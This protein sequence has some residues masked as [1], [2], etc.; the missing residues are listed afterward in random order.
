[1]K[2]VKNNIIKFVP[3]HVFEARK[4]PLYAYS[5]TN[6]FDEFLA[7]MYLE[8]ETLE[9]HLAQRA[10]D[11]ISKSKLSMNEVKGIQG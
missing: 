8:G 7:Q 2:I 1:M 11:F 4:C 3:R 6:N 10:K 5:I 9:P